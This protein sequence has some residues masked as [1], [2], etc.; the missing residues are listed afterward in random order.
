M[1]SSRGRLSVSLHPRAP[2][3]GD[4]SQ[5]FVA[6]QRFRQDD[7]KDMSTSSAIQD[8]SSPGLLDEF[9]R[10]RSPSCLREV[11]TLGR[12][13]M[14][15][16][17]DEHKNV[18]ATSQ[19]RL[20]SCDGSFS[21]LFSRNQTSLVSPVCVLLLLTACVLFF[22]GLPFLWY[23]A[24]GF[25][26]LQSLLFL[27]SLKQFQIPSKRF[28]SS[29]HACCFLD[30][31]KFLL[32]LPLLFSA[33]SCQPVQA[34]HL[35]PC[36]ALW[37]GDRS[38]TPSHA[39]SSVSSS[40]SDSPSSPLVF[41]PASLH[42]SA[43]RRG[44]GWRR[45]DRLKGDLESSPALN[46]KEKT[47]TITLHSQHLG[48][49]LSPG[50]FL[51]KPK[52]PFRATT[53]NAPLPPA[54][55]SST[56]VFA[57]SLCASEPASSSSY[58]VS[59]AST[60]RLPTR[61]VV[62][63]RGAHAAPYHDFFSSAS[64]ASSALPP[65]GS[66]REGYPVLIGGA[67]PLVVQTMTNSDT[68]D[69]QATV[70]QIR[71]CAEAGASMVR[72][73]VQGMKEVEASKFIK[74]KL[75]Q[76]NL[77][78]PLVADVH[79]QPRVGLAAAEIFDKVRINPGNFADGAK[80]WEDEETG[81]QT[82]DSRRETEDERKL[83]DERNREVESDRRFDDGHKRIEELLVPLVEKCKAF[84]TALRIGTNHGSLSARILRR[85]GDTPRGMV[86]S[87]FEFSDICVR[88][89][90]R[91][92]CFSM[93][94]S[95]PK[96][97]VHAYRLLASEMLR[98]NELFPIHLGV[99]EAGE[100]EDG[101]LKS[102]VGIGSLLQ[103]GIGDTLRV[104]LTEPPWEEIPVALSIARMQGQKIRRSTFAETGGS[105]A[106]RRPP[107]VSGPDLGDE[108]AKAII[109]T[110]EGDKEDNH[111]RSGPGDEEETFGVSKRRQTENRKSM[112]A[113][114]RALPDLER[115]A[116]FFSSDVP[117]GVLRGFEEKMRNFENIE[118]RKI[119]PLFQK[120]SLAGGQTAAERTG[121]G[122]ETPEKRQ[123]ERI[124]HRD[125]TLMVRVSPEWLEIPEVLY[126]ALGCRVVGGK[127]LRT[128]SSVDSIYVSSLSLPSSDHDSRD[129][130]S[131]AAHA[132]ETLHALQEAGIGVLVPFQELAY[133][134]SLEQQQKV[135]K[136]SHAG[137][138]AQGS[139]AG[140][141]RDNH[142]EEAERERLLLQTSLLPSARDGLVG[143]L[144]L[145]DA[146]AVRGRLLPFVR[147]RL[148]GVALLADGEETEEE[149]DAVLEM[150]ALLFFLLRPHA[151]PAHGVAATRRFL[152]ILKRREEAEAKKTDAMRGGAQPKE[153]REE[154]P[155][156]IPVIHWLER[157]AS[158]VAEN[159][160]TG[161]E[162][163][164][165]DR[166][167][168]EQKEERE[169]ATYAGWEVGSLLMDALGEGVLVDL[170]ALS[171]P[172]Q[173]RLGFNLLQACRL[174]NTKTEF[175]SCPSCGRTL[176][177]IQKVSAEIRRRTGHLPGVTIAVM[178][179]IVNGVG[180]MADADFGYVGGAPG[181]VDLYV[182]KKVVKRG[183]SSAEACDALVDLI[184]Q[185]GRWVD[186]PKEMAEGT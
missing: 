73:T 146:A 102:A 124:L 75:D 86:E 158:A 65:P 70:E 99:T 12:E 8:S 183:I 167:T 82:G 49:A 88:E 50:S 180:E 130:I 58:C 131:R 150:E 141:T 135:T 179:C 159:D 115:D 142:A 113:I 6:P 148:D 47:K 128:V 117:S 52:P 62:V 164:K 172:R 143:I 97:M 89:N 34:V 100:G 80:K 64:S 138:G 154:G 3:R 77:P 155:G 15:R 33:W 55:S 119:R 51:A 165:A 87:A 43:S 160:I 126:K 132:R 76:A 147:D 17:G 116:V 109:G 103:D 11:R 39:L 184:K 134:L 114:S 40:F 185:H 28:P 105:V 27:T 41:F 19:S 29:V 136:A 177:D 32:L 57:S 85:Y 10:R 122:A 127:P 74:E 178:G 173:I 68:R 140:L 170:P 53:Q 186:P 66:W 42:P 56:S 104:S 71:K 121:D 137:R 90:F 182:K 161:E 31:S 94:S 95:N 145:R 30:R 120:Q 166:V 110:G 67:H 26:S 153:C 139:E 81:G 35:R 107:G 22:G 24:E 129:L 92:F 46:R 16:R 171:L 59:V 61:T 79:F 123:E 84:N 93:K 18:N 23:A 48:F 118:K 37:G 72:V 63:G 45:S 20:A 101:R 106:G 5:A 4:Q 162:K 54:A 60:Q 174:R 133:L 108:R 44:Y 91:N 112:S 98:R 7:K 9:R 168:R 111:R 151:R 169:S 156:G 149:I 38:S 36:R 152:D 21:S 83:G 157:T 14:V 175:I 125:G 2:V 25:A 69:V 163:E 176:F 181:K 1:E 144:R 96:V 78:I 13:G